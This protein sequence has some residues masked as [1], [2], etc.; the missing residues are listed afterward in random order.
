MKRDKTY[1]KSK[2]QRET[3][4]N[5]DESINKL[6]IPCFLRES[7]KVTSPSQLLYRESWKE[8]GREH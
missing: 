1:R 4:I 8:K 2:R 3:T 5:A 7:E 6:E